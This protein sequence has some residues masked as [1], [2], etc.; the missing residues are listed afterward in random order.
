MTDILDFFEA[1]ARPFMAR[2]LATALIL[3]SICAIVGIFV[4][5]RRMVFLVD[6][7]S[8]SAFSGGALAILIGSNPLLTIT[9]F[10][11]LSAFSIGAIKEKG[12]LN[13]ETAIGIIFSFTMALGIIFV[14]LIRTYTTGVQGLLFGSVTSIDEEEFAIIVLTAIGVVAAMLLLKQKFFFMTFNEELAKAYGLPVRAL[15][16]AFLAIVSLVIVVCLKAVGV[17]LQI[18]MIVTPAAC[19]YQ[20]TYNTNKMLLL[21]IVIALVGAFLGFMLGYVLEIAPSASIIAVYTAIFVVTMVA[22]PKRRHK[23]A[24]LDEKMCI[25]CNRALAATGACEYCDVD[26]AAGHDG[27]EHGGE[28]AN[29]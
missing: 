16:Y 8:H 25:E 21:A 22:S 11:V 2:S 13:N 24:M 18:A 26:A 28:H 20:L 12:K 3:A 1:L 29:H 23:R 27:H 10:S 7:I 6:G 4:I 17:I 15:S 5:L 14:G 19:A 9:L